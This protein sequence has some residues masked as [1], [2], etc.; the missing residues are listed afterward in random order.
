MASAPPAHDTGQHAHGVEYFSVSQVAVGQVLGHHMLT[1]GIVQQR[2]G[3]DFVDDGK[4]RQDDTC[5]QGEQ[6][7]PGVEQ[8]EY[9]DINRHPRCIEESKKAI[10]GK[11]LAKCRQVIQRLRRGLTGHHQ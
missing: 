1:I 5:P 8:R 2:F 3:G 10:A 9:A 4:C 6:P 11:K 7:K